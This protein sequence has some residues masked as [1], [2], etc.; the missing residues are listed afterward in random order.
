MLKVA[1]ID[2]RLSRKGA[3]GLLPSVLP[4]VTNLSLDTNCRT[5]RTASTLQLVGEQ[6]LRS[7]FTTVGCQDRIQKYVLIEEQFS[8]K[9][10]IA[11]L[12]LKF[13]RVENEAD[14]YPVNLFS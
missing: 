12:V 8:H 13:Y 14:F 6:L 10:I 9:Y 11:K 3:A 5:V 2:L 1:R 4:R 7:R